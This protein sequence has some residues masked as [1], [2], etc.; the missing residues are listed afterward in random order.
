VGL[1]VILFSCVSIHLSVTP[2]IWLSAFL[3]PIHCPAPEDLLH[4]PA[5][6]PL[7]KRTRAHTTHSYTQ[8]LLTLQSPVQSMFTVQMLCIH[9]NAVLNGT[10]EKKGGF[11]KKIAVGSVWKEV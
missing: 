9:F 5:T 6:S 3:T 10:L 2:S 11:G 7:N 8:S 4:S 1:P